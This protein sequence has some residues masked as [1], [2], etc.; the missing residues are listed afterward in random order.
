MELTLI[1]SIASLGTAP[2]PAVPK[3]SLS[4]SSSSSSL[5]S[6][7]EW[8]QLQRPRGAFS[9]FPSS[10]KLKTMASKHTPSSDWSF[11]SP[12]PAAFSDDELLKN[13]RSK[14]RFRHDFATGLAGAKTTSPIQS[15][16][17]TFIGNGFGSADPINKKKETLQFSPRQNTKSQH[18]IETK[19]SDSRSIRL[20]EHETLNFEHENNMRKHSDEDSTK[21]LH[22]ILSLRE[23]SPKKKKHLVRS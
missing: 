6:E 22:F 2:D 5:P 10:K 14:S 13:C 23:K 8:K 20:R 3:A 17:W 21:R 4:S 11:P 9:W 15:I 16:G 1:A 18:K 7:L 19:I 12:D